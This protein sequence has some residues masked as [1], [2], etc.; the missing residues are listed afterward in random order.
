M[1]SIDDPA[2]CYDGAQRSAIDPPIP[3]L[4]HLRALIDLGHHHDALS[5]ARR[6]ELEHRENPRIMATAALVLGRVALADEALTDAADHF[7]RAYWLASAADEPWAHRLAGEAAIAM[8]HTSWLSGSF[9]QADDW[10]RHAE[11]AVARVEDD[12]LADDLTLEI[13][14]LE[15]HLGK[16]EAAE[17]RVQTLLERVA[18]R[19][20]SEARW[21]RALGLHL[22][23]LATR[24]AYELALQDAEL[25]LAVARDAFGDEHPI[26]ATAH[27]HVAM[28]HDYAGRK[29]QTLAALR[30]SL[31][32]QQAAFG[33]GHV[34]VARTKAMIGN[35]LQGL[36]RADEAKSDLEHA[37][38]VT[39]R[40]HGPHHRETGEMVGLLATN[41]VER[42]DLAAADPLSARE[43]EI[44]GRWLPEHTDQI[45]IAKGARAELLLLLGRT[46]ESEALAQDAILGARAVAGPYSSLEIEVLNVLLRVWLQQ[47]RADEALGEATRALMAIQSREETASRDAALMLWFQGKAHLQL[48]ADRDAAAALLAA[49]VTIDRGGIDQ[50]PL[51]AS[52]QLDLATALARAG[53]PTSARN[54]AELAIETFR[55]LDD[56]TQLAVAERVLA[57]LP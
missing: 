25:S 21:R 14:G 45:V 36:G 41:A 53:Q 38:A 11:V 2:S 24:G 35:T 44:L 17:Q 18:E 34:Q 40:I 3:E 16:H 54:A 57:D 49:I 33:P 13:A 10:R 4:A 23:L 5:T 15:R 39:E 37:L 22:E 27:Y 9:A 55:E 20:G 31:R 7:A 32:I 50:P 43:L 56:E 29:E 8:F 12:E 19:P 42:G 6:L 48:G 46:H 47:G 26:T 28:A 51:T 30:E 52:I 1:R